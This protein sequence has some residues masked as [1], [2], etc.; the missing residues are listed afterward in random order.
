MWV[1]SRLYLDANPRW[2]VD[3][4]C[5]G[6]IL[7]QRSRS[8]RGAREARLR[9]RGALGA[10]LIAFAPNFLLGCLFPWFLSTRVHVAGSLYAINSVGAILGALAAAPLTAGVLTLEGTYR[11]GIAAVAL[12]LA[13]G[14]ALSRRQRSG[15]APSG[16]R[17]MAG[18]FPTPPPLKRPLQL[19]IWAEIIFMKSFIKVFSEHGNRMILGQQ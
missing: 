10:G 13:S 12:L 15:D 19:D 2:F 3:A 16:L 8:R 4:V 14:I 7:V 18:V 9:A 5:G 6:G 1:V 11:L 17:T